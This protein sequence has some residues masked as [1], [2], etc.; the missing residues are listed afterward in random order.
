MIINSVQ[1]LRILFVRRPAMKNI[2]EKIFVGKGQKLW[3]I[4]G[5]K[6]SFA[7]FYL[8]KMVK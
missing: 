8:S 7:K 6:L 5:S 1:N 3:A 2:P 4:Y